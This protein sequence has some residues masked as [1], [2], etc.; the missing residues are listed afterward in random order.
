MDGGRRRG[1][2]SLAC[3]LCA[4]DAATTVE[5][6]NWPWLKCNLENFNLWG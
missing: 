6:I 3:L 4:R 1:A 5:R 2:H